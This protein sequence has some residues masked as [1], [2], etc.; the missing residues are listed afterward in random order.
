MVH[1]K[2]VSTAGSQTPAQSPPADAFLLRAGWAGGATRQRVQRLPNTSRHA[3][4][5][6]SEANEGT[7]CLPQDGHSLMPRTREAVSSSAAQRTP[8][9]GL[10][11]HLYRR[12]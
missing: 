11:E 10:R 1:P 4:A 6:F 5:A 12:W 8:A 3:A 7:G 2:I 9:D